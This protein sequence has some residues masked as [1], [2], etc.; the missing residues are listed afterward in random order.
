MVESVFGLP[1]I[2]LHIILLGSAIS[3]RANN[4]SDNSKDK[5]LDPVVKVETVKSDSGTLAK[6]MEMTRSKYL[7]VNNSIHFKVLIKSLRFRSELTIEGSSLDIK[8]WNLGNTRFRF[9]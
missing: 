3:D 4:N 1:H 7:S 2:T 9:P 5:E 8:M 6:Y